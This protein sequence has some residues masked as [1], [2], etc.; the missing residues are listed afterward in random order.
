MNELLSNAG[1]KSG[2]WIL[3]TDVDEIPRPSTIDLLRN[4]QDIPSPLHLQL[5][6]YLYS[7]EF[8]PDMDSWRA[9]AAIYPFPYGHSRSSDSLLTDAGWHCSFCFRYIKDFQ[10]KM[11]GYS[12]ADRVHS[13]SYL[14]PDRIQKIICDGGDLYNM[15]P[16]AYTFKDLFSKW[17]LI[18]KQ[19][20]AIDLPSV[21]LA[22]SKKFKYLL[23]GNCLRDQER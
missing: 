9:K 14:D 7:F 15:L 19:T 6:N 12:H 5:K 4:C 16:E 2:D 23:P 18:P 10:F 20:S 3:M 8:L 13:K 1:A 21:V 11:Q 22:E 17:D